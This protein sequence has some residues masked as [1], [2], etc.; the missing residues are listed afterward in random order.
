MENGALALILSPKRIKIIQGLPENFIQSKDNLLSSDPY[1]V[2]DREY[3]Y[4]CSYWKSEQVVR[5]RLEQ[6]LLKRSQQA[7]CMALS[8]DVAD[9]ILLGWRE[10]IEL[11]EQST[12]GEQLYLA[13]KRVLYSDLLILSGGP[14]SGKTYSLIRLLTLL[15]HA[16]QHTHTP[17]RV[18]LT[19]PTAKAVAR[20]GEG[21]SGLD[22]FASCKVELLTLHKAL[23]AHGKGRYRY[24]NQLQW[25]YDVVVMDESSM[26]DISLFYQLLGALKEPSK[27]FIVGDA[28]QL[29]S[30]HSGAVLQDLVYWTLNKDEIPVGMR[31]LL[32]DSTIFL[33][34]SKRSTGEILTLAQDFLW[35]RTEAILQKYQEFFFSQVD[36]TTSSILFYPLKKQEKDF[37]EWVIQQYGLRREERYRSLG[38]YDVHSGLTNRQREQ[39][40]QLFDR[41]SDFS[42]LTPTHDGAYGVATINKQIQLIIGGGSRLYH[43]LPIVLSKNQSIL[44]LSNGDRGV[45]VQFHDIYYAAFKDS[46]GEFVL[47]PPADLYQYEV[48]YAITIHKSQGSEYTR[49]AV[50]L[51]AIAKRLLENRLVY[52]AITRAKRQVV[53]FAEQEELKQGSQASSWSRTSQ[54]A[55]YVLS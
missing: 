2:L 7:D 10:Q 9:R 1:F 29:P 53:I 8:S 39:I 24:G 6:V 45:V 54:L 4:L 36:R 46:R 49:V 27:L 47:Y 50:V 43:G 5:V 52:T 15:N 41:Y 31:N 23:G 35:S 48:A 16:S 12:M 18:L 3:L 22:I 28:N 55:Y 21:L 13:G 26:V 33:Q 40:Q 30:I 25:D 17:L 44:N 51:P 11:S 34:G 19:A 37:Y 14:G 20:M 42:V 38:S 32:E